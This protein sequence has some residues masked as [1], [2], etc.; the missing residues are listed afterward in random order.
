MQWLCSKSV[1][2]LLGILLLLATVVVTFLSPTRHFC[3]LGSVFS[4]IPALLFYHCAPRTLI[5]RSL[6]V[7]HSSAGLTHVSSC[8]VVTRTIHSSARPRRDHPLMEPCV[9]MERYS[10]STH[11]KKN[12]HIGGKIEFD[13][14]TILLFCCSTASKVN[15]CG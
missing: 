11:T 15:A 13:L 2:L 10:Y 1:L 8:G 9:G 14:L 5:I 3:F 4:L 12:T 7:P 6:S